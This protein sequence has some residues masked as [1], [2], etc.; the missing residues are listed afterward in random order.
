[1][2]TVFAA[3]TALRSIAPL[4]GRG[5]TSTIRADVRLRSRG[6]WG[7]SFASEPPSNL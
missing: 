6:A 2:N 5:R 3:R 7:P 1:M 4:A